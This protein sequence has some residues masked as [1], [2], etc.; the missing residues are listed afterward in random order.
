MI[1]SCHSFLEPEAESDLRRFF[2]YDECNPHNCWGNR[3]SMVVRLTGK[4]I[5]GEMEH[6]IT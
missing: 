2:Q 1:V 3:S 6:T 4:Q 5:D